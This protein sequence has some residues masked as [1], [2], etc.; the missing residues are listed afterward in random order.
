MVTWEIIRH[1]VAIAG[2]VTDART[3]QAIDG[4]QVRITAAPTAFTDWLAIRALQDGVRWAA[5]AE[6]PDQ[7]RSAAD[8]HFH[9]L[10]LPNGLYTLT[11]MLP[12][13]GSRYG[14]AAKQVMVSRN[15]QGNVTM[16]AADMTLPRTTLMGEVSNQG[17]TSIVLAEVRV[18][19]S[20]E[21]AFSDAQ[22]RYL[23]A[24]LEVGQ[25]TVMVSAQ[26]YQPASQTVVISTAGAEH[27][28]NVVL[29]P[30]AP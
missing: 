12:G 25:R 20:G 10:D 21:R 22:G 14:T 18:R 23:L 13:S 5:M 3:G 6:R 26:G 19:G 24:G 1:Q 4:A 8:G 17:G 29:V 30:S 7:T 11:A 28:F 16:A 27:T 2:T 9:F 15:A